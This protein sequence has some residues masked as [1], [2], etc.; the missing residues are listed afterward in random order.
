MNMSR[1]MILIFFLMILLIVTINTYYLSIT[2]IASFDDL[3]AG[4]FRNMAANMVRNAEQYFTMMDLAIEDLCSDFDFL[5]LEFST[6]SRIF[7]TADSPNSFV[8]LIL[9]TP[10]ILI[11]PLITS[12]PG[13]ASRFLHNSGSLQRE[14]LQD[15]RIHRKYCCPAASD[16]RSPHRHYKRP[17]PFLCFRTSPTGIP[18]MRIRNEC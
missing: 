4:R 7:D 11:Q 12:S 6:R 2:N 5:E 17:V 13:S 10:V 8:V 1:R 18:R 15:S 3:S 9:S 14:Y 16:P